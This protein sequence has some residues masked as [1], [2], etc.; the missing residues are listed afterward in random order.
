MPNTF[1]KRLHTEGVLN[2]VAPSNEVK[3]AYL[4]KSESHLI[5]AKLLL[6]NDLFE[7][8]VSMA[9]FHPLF[10]IYIVLYLNFLGFIGILSD[11]FFLSCPIRGTLRAWRFCCKNRGERVAAKREIKMWG[12][13]CS[14]GKITCT[15]LSSPSS[16]TVH[17]R[18]EYLSP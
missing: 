10:G 12:G 7:E 13:T 11:I 15:S 1:L 3:R 4:K 6:E 2:L 17:H 16:R 14:P 18:Q 8:S 5:S 9:Y